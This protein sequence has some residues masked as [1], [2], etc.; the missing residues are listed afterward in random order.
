[1]PIRVNTNMTSLLIGNQ[2]ARS[3]AQ[4]DKTFAQLSSGL[5][6][7]MAAD[8]AAGMGI[9]ES[10]RSEMRSLRQANRNTMDGISMVQTAESSLGE[11]GGRLSRMRE[12]AVQSANGTLNPADRNAIQAEFS[13]LQSEVERIANVTEFNGLSLSNGSAATPVDVQVGANNVAAN[14]RV[15]VNLQ[16]VRATTLGVD[17]ASINVATQ[18]GAQNAITAIDNAISQV[19]AGRSAYGATQNQLTSAMHNVQSYTE[20]LVAAESRIR[21]VDF[22][23]G[24]AEK[25]RSQI[26][27]QASISL[28]AQSNVSSQTALGLLK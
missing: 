22:A 11:V 16:D 17:P 19:S 23:A 18:A 15:A 7:N 20:N 12:L 24:V 4:L 3:K 28:L 26:L 27:N 8:D 5:R 14:D 21:D 6:I 1:M 9:S 2:A 13:A 25:T 10:L